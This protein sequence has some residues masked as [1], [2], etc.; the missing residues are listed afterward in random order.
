MHFIQRW[1]MHT[2]THPCCKSIS[3][4]YLCSSSSS[5]RWPPYR[6]RCVGGPIPTSLI[7]VVVLL[8]WPLSSGHKLYSEVW[9]IIFHQTLVLITYLWI[10]F[11][12]LV[13]LLLQQEP[14]TNVGFL[15]RRHQKKAS[16]QDGWSQFFFFFFYMLFL[17]VCCWCE[18]CDRHTTSAAAT[19]SIR[20][21]P[22]VALSLS[23]GGPSLSL[24]R[25]R[26]G[27]T[28]IS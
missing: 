21:G 28:S 24:R 7:G 3:I 6:V 16:F 17:G 23:Q 8:Y 1:Y 19:L 20:P 22:S 14:W 27:Q 18:C 13:G 9:I 2:N 12:I 15:L 11:C 25:V 26:C 5:S 10:S 4:Y